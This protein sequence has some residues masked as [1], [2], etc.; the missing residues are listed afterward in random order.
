MKGEIAMAKRKYYAVRQGRK[1]GIYGTWEECQEQTKGFPDAKFKSFGTLGEAEKYLNEVEPVSDVTVKNNS[2]EDPEDFNKRVNEAIENL[3][4]EESIAFVD[5]SYDSK[6][7]KSGFGVIIISEGNSRDTLY[8]AFSK[9]LDKEFLAIHNVAAELEGV[10][11]AVNWAIK[12]SKKK[13]TIY[14]DYTGIECWATG[15][16]KAK[17]NITQNYARFIKDMQSQV[18]IKFVKVPAHAGVELNEEAD[19]LA[20]KALLTKGHKTYND[21]SVYFYGLGLKEWQSIVKFIDNENQELSSGT[22]EKI[23]FSAEKIDKRDKVTI[24]H[25]RD[26]VVINCYSGN[27]SYAQGK[28]TVLFQ[29]IIATAIEFLGTDTGVVETLNNYYALTI[30]EENV[31]MEFDRL[32]PNYTGN[33]RDKNYL[34]LLSAVYNTMLTGYMPDYTCLVTP[35]FRGYEFCLHRILGDIM[36]LQ[37]ERDNG[38]NNFA[39]FDKDS[40]RKYSCNSP[41]T[42]KLSLVQKEF[43]DE[44]YTNYNSVRHPYSHWSATDYDN[45]VITEI[46]K[47]REHLLKGLEIVNRYYKLF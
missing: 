28:Q 8:K 33:Y 9:K 10:K 25:L 40:T 11:E 44:L 35:I 6:E 7:E 17:N 5:G 37:T 38:T 20:K 45:A 34:N 18:D 47:A 31:K 12:Y 1:P 27:R 15:E 29:K 26:R 23:E 32:L 4:E 30:T 16:W 46:D 41:E 2:N 21:G 43:L 13:L 19:A 24:S 36:G 22:I 3:K 39:Y 42:S 14:Y